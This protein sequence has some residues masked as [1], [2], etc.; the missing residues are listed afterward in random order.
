MSGDLGLDT[1]LEAGNLEVDA[2]K[3]ERVKTEMRQVWRYEPVDHIPVLIDIGPECGVTV[4]DALLDTEAWFSSA[5]R[6]IERS[7]RVLPDDYVPWVGPPWAAFHTVPVMLGAQLWWEQDPD[8]FPAI[9]SPVVTEIDQVYEL[10]DPDP[11]SSGMAPEILRR[12]ELAAECFPREVSLV[13]ADMMSPLGDVLGLMDQTLFFVSL[14]SHPEAIHHACEVVTRAQIALQDAALAVVGTSDRFAAL[15]NWPIWRPEE[16]KALVTD[17][18]ASLLGPA[19]FERFDRPYGDRLLARYGGGLRHVCGPHPSLGTYVRGEQMV[20]GLNCSFRYSR[21]SLRGM[22][23]EFGRFAEESLGRRGHLEVMFE[24]QVPLGEM[25]T[26]FRQL[27]EELAP[28]VVAIPYCQVPA[29]G[30]VSDD[31]ITRFYCAM[32]AVAED[33]AKS[34]RWR[35]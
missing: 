17:D 9:K 27:A 16:G 28:D 19:V 23:E 22:K 14:K 18:I 13:G 35:A 33:Y 25:V 2:E 7:L 21:D 6:R 4:R 8:A 11:Y 31:E 5:V 29:D 10:R 24:R 15:S 26:G 32:R 34:M 30:S 1:R 12:L 3:C 20:R